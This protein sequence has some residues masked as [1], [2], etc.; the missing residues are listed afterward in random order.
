MPEDQL[1]FVNRDAAGQPR[2]PPNDDK[3]HIPAGDP[4]KVRPGS[5]QRVLRPVR[6]STAELR[7]ERE[8]FGGSRWDIPGAE[9]VD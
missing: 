6:F 1:L 9:D 8:I 3:F 4:A 2:V 5:V 7:G